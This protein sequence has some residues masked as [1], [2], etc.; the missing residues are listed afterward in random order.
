MKNSLIEQCL[1]NS[2]VSYKVNTAY[3]ERNNL[4]LRQHNHRVERKTQGFSKEVEYMVGHNSFSIGYYNL[5][6]PHSSLEKYEGGR[7]AS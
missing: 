7:E 6:L 5:C 2:Q 3:V 1:A 4:T